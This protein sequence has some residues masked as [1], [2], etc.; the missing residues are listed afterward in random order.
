M[1]AVK[2]LTYPNKEVLMRW[3]FNPFGQKD[4][5]KKQRE[6]ARLVAV[7]RGF[8]YLYFLGCD[9]IPPS[10][11][12]ELLLEAEGFPVIGGVYFG[13]N[14]IIDHVVAWKEGY[15]PEQFSEMA[16]G[17]LDEY[18]Y[19]YPDGMGMDSVLIHSEIFRKF[20]WMSYVVND[21]D[22]PFYD[23]LNSENIP[24]VLDTFAQ[25]KHYFDEDGKV[26]YSLKGVKHG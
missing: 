12:I 1:E 20:S 11:I 14:K 3:D 22:Y 2:N 23:W 15:S 7:D 5:V 16:K 6:F 17:N 9:T 10:N 8:D 24:I 19:L 26:F 18:R 25:C 13:R 4:N 21:D